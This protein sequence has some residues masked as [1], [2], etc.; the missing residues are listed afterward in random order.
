M[1]GPLSA[2]KITGAFAAFHL[3]FALAMIGV[4]DAHSGRGTVHNGWWGPKILL[5]AGSIVG[6]LFLPPQF[7]TV[8]GWISVVG[9]VGFTIIQLFML[10]DFAHTWNDSWVEKYHTTNNKNW[11]RLLLVATLV[12]FVLV[13]VGTVLMYVFLLGTVNSPYHVMNVAI[14]SLNIGLCVIIAV[15]SVLPRVQHSNPRASL[16]T[17]SIVCAYATYLI[18]SALFSEPDPDCLAATSEFWFFC[19][20]LRV[21]H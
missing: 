8:Y 12:L 18:W 10:V 15:V 16:L 17:S 20:C 11:F 4:H 5:W 1:L 19:G 7:L 3:L 9:S 21:F 2:Y 6:F 14:V 13:L